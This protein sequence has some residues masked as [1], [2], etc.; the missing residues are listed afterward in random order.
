M[1]I[2]GIQIGGGDTGTTGDEKPEERTFSVG[3]RV[4]GNR[5]GYTIT[6][7]VTALFDDGAA[8]SSIESALDS[9]GRHVALNVDYFVIHPNGE[10]R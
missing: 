1:K 6:G 5:N 8:T 9:S 7:V 2:F 10:I 4:G 3:D